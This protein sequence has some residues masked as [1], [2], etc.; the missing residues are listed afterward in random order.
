MNT[1]NNLKKA[2]I[3]ADERSIIDLLRQNPDLIHAYIGEVSV[4]YFAPN[5]DIFR[6][7]VS[8]GASIQQMQKDGTPALWRFA[9]IGALDIVQHLTTLGVDVNATISKS[10]M[11]PLHSAA[12]AEIA[13]IL[14][15]NGADIEAKDT[16]GVTSIS[17]ASFWGEVDIVSA[18]IDAGAQID[19]CDAEMRTALHRACEESKTNVV[20]LLVARGAN[21]NAADQDL[22][23]PLHIASRLGE[24]SITQALVNARADSELRNAAGR[25]PLIEAKVAGN[26]AIVSFLR[27]TTSDISNAVDV[28]IERI[29]AHPEH[30]AITTDKSAT[31]CIWINSEGGPAI[32]QTTPTDEIGFVTLRYLANE[33]QVVALASGGIVQFRSWPDL[34]V[35]RQLKLKVPKAGSLYSEWNSAAVSPD[36]RLLVFC[37]FEMVKAFVF[38]LQTNKLIKTFSLETTGTGPVAFSPSGEYFS[39]AWLDEGPSLIRIYR[40]L[41]DG[42]IGDMYLDED[43]GI[44][45]MLSQSEEYRIITG[46]S[47]NS[48]G[49]QFALVSRE[50]VAGNAEIPHVVAVHNV[51]DAAQVW[52]ARLDGR[53]PDEA[54]TNI[55][56]WNDVIKQGPLIWCGDVLLIGTSKGEIVGLAASSGHILWRESV[57]GAERIA[58]MALIDGTH[59]L[60]VDERRQIK[61][62]DLK[63]K[64]TAS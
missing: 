58:D 59:L 5:V 8:H 56:V 44:G 32:V 18:L 9:S 16:R 36:G 51:Q 33:N 1:I 64:L 12:N 4:L 31:L 26:K 39:I 35:V 30:Q 37:V 49:S 40:V 20:E 24:I 17:E 62:I 50:D 13:R 42:S 21:V 47:F 29:Y 11:T 55:R 22:N 27:S 45:S 61:S 15:A 28:P 53:L 10:G 46:A 41:P 57:P 34:A 48:D 38:N 6:L 3:D 23:T 54:L 19:S 2:V 60:I 14:I 43:D 52:S 63:D 25:T 7:L